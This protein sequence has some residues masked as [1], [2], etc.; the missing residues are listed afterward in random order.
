MI[1]DLS[2]FQMANLQRFLKHLL[3][4]DDHNASET[5]IRSIINREAEPKT[6]LEESYDKRIW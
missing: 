5:Y 3:Q 4:G 6:M 1:T 2:L